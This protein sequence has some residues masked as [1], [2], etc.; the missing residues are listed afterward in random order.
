MRLDGTTS[1]KK[2]QQLVNRF[3]GKEDIFV[4]LLSSKV[5]VD[6]LLCHIASTRGR[7]IPEGPV[8]CA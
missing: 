5:R 7:L 4:F 2:R 1:V 3:N 6:R 8:V